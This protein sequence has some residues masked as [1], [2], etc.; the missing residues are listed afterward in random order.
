ML[1]IDLSLKAVLLIFQLFGKAQLL[2]EM[3]NCLSK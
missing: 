2:L 3:F 1:G